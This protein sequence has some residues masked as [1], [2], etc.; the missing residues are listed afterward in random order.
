MHSDDRSQEEILAAS[1]TIANGPDE[2]R[3]AKAKARE[4]GIF[5]ANARIAASPI[6]RALASETLRNLT[7]IDPFGADTKGGWLS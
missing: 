4:L 2:Q 5:D 3:R 7:S 1:R 6:G